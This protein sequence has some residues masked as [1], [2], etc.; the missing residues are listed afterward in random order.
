MEESKAIATWE[1]PDGLAKRMNRLIDI[2]KSVM[3]SDVD[4]GIIPGCAKPTL[5]KPGAE[6]LCV[7]FNV[8][9]RMSDGYPERIEEDGH[10]R[11]I[12]KLDFYDR[13]SNTY[14][15]FGIGECSS[16]EKKYC[17]RASVCDEEFDETDSNLK[18]V[19]YKKSGNNVYKNKQ[20]R[21][22]PADLANTILKMAKKRAKVDGVLNV[23][24]ASR[25]FAQD[26]EDLPEG[27]DVS[28]V[29]HTSTKPKVTPTTAKVATATDERPDD[30]TRK[31][32]KWISEGQEKRIYAI[33]KSA[34]VELE[35]LRAWLYDS[36]K[37]EH[38]HQIT[39]AGKQYDKVCDAIETKADKI[40]GYAAKNTTASVDAATPEAAPAP[41]AKERFAEMQQA[42]TLALG[43]RVDAILKAVIDKTGITIGKWGETE[44]DAATNALADAMEAQ[45]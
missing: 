1:T 2:Q 44:Y 8:A 35:D 27:L 42:A 17:W 37:I 28:S 38:L 7:T 40:K 11:Y 39:W 14:L 41:G 26:L 29:E 10:V 6:L 5:L 21:T 32:N 45:G 25:V 43:E 18:R 23:L 16:A 22:N 30:E 24:G 20:I 4:F 15:G 31:K 3:K 36:L 9:D 13:V 12:V 33:C 34:K 19:E